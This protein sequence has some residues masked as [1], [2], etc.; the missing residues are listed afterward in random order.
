MAYDISAANLEFDH[1]SRTYDRSL[2][3]RYLFRPS[4]QT[5][6][7]HISAG[8]ETL[9]DIG[10]G[11]GQFAAT[12]LSRFPR[13]NVWGIDLS[14]KMLDQGLSRRHAWAGRLHVTRGDSERLPFHDSSFDVVT[15]SHS[16][17]HYPRQAAVVAEMFRVLRPN[18][19]LLILDGQRDSWWGWFIFDVIVTLVE[20]GV[21]HCS[22]G[23]FRRLFRN[24]SFHELRQLKRGWPIPYLL[25]V[26]SA[27]KSAV[28]APL[29][30]THA[31]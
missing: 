12:A 13:L 9:L 14:A 3:Q 2:L 27:N 28:L 23:H 7:E 17:H 22:A 15:C 8:D 16:F 5:L 11:T 29:P 25:T 4:H 1:W 19:K 31:A 18:G 26:G 10:C 30:T 6:L 24:A 20:G 21:H